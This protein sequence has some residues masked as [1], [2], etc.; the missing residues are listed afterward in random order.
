VQIRRLTAALLLLAV[1]ACASAP[2]PAAPSAPRPTVAATAPPAVVAAAAAI[3]AAAVQQHVDVLASD[4]LRGRDTPSPGLEQAAQYLVERLAALGL[5]PAGTDGFIQRWDFEESRLDV[6][7]LRVEARTAAGVLAPA[8]GRELFVLP[9]RVDSVVGEP[10]FAGRA[11]PGVSVG[12]AAADRIVFFFVADT[13]GPAWQADVSAA[14]QAS[15]DAGAGAVVLVL[16]SLF[17]E[18]ALGMLAGELAGEVA[19]LPVLGLRYDAARDVFRHAGL[20]LG[21]VRGNAGPPLPLAGVTFA[22]RTPIRP[23][24]AQVP[25]VVAVLPG[26]DAQRAAE[27][28]VYSAHFDHVGVGVPDATG[29]SIYNGA[30]DN[31]SGTSALL[32]IA[33]AFAGLERAPPRSV[34]FVFVSGEEK[35]L[36][37]SRHFVDQPPV[38]TDRMIANINADMIGRNAP[39]TVVAI[40][41]TYTTL[42]ETVQAVARRHPELGLVV[43]PDLWPQERL[44]FRSDHFSFAAAEVPAIFFTTGLHDD[45]H[46]PSDRAELIDADKLARVA[47]LLFLFGHELATMAER[48]AWTPEGLTAVRRALIG[49][50]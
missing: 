16:D 22:M 13:L 39:D 44:F 4:S 7:A 34:M 11:R 47:R 2:P 38:P 28:V 32:E 23:I 17:G 20:E 42:G 5:Q 31:A 45:Y 26:S 29:D 37:G 40:G 15:F 9:A 18:P 25:N 3:T 10:V 41:Q 24:A 36:L 49:G 21:A 6:A 33:R 50:F 14:L 1:S 46:R 12:A 30:D 8:F 35:G 43:A 48:P 19:P 27:H